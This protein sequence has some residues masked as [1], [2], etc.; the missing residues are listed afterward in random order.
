MSKQ[1]KSPGQ[2]IGITNNKERR[3]ESRKILLVLFPAAHCLFYGGKNF[4]PDDVRVGLG[5]VRRSFYRNESSSV[6]SSVST[7]V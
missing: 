1:I 2:I 5:K 6:I 4:Q 3:E 7:C